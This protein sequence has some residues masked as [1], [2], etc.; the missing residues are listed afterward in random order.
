MDNFAEVSTSLFRQGGSAKNIA[1]FFCWIK[2]LGKEPEL[3]QQERKHPF[4]LIFGKVIHHFKY[5]KC[6]SGSD[7]FLFPR[8]CSFINVSCGVSVHS[9]LCSCLF[10][11]IFLPPPCFWGAT[12]MYLKTEF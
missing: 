8:L 2:S 3:G 7:F 6:S 4:E 10:H 1:V 11:W 9:I 5:L 12:Q